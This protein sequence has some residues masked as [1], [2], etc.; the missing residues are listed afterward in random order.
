M[1]IL[2]CDFTG[3]VPITASEF[4]DGIYQ[5]VG[6]LEHYAL[7]LPGNPSDIA[8]VSHNRL[9][10]HPE[11]LAG[12]PLERRACISLENGMLIL[13]FI[14]AKDEL[15]DEG[16]RKAKP[17]VVTP[18]SVTPYL[19]LAQKV[20]K[21]RNCMNPNCPKGR[22][23]VLSFRQSALL[24]GWAFD[25]EDEHLLCPECAQAEVKK[26]PNLRDAVFYGSDLMTNA[27][28]AAVR[29]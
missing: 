19:F 5:L 10:I 2:S 29:S 22:G 12:I 8:L 21:Y 25:R 15:I 20:E 3:I 24:I 11:L 4:G 16:W 7:T 14:N 17:L 18:T 9:Y 13:N 26:D 27:L 23:H 1:K 28:V 6:T